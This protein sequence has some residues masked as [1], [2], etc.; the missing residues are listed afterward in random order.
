MILQ[1]K[2]CPARKLSTLLTA[3]VL[4]HFV[5]LLTRAQTLI[6]E[7]STPCKTVVIGFVGGMR[8]P[9]D[10]S[11]GVV[12]I[13]NRLKNLNQANLQVRTYSHWH[14]KQA[15]REI[16]QNIDQNQ[17]GALSKEEIR[18]A[19]K[20]VIYGHSLGGW[21]VLK[22]SRKLEKKGIP[23]EL[24]VQID[25]VGIGDEMVPGN[26]RSA[27]NYYQRTLP[28]LRGEKR[29]RAEDK[30]KTDV[31]GNF[32]IRDVGHE[33]LARRTEI[34]DFIIAN[35]RRL[36]IGSALAPDTRGSRVRT[37]NATFLID[38]RQKSADSITLTTDH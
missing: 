25:S 37:M 26:V 28:I 38:D 1:T 31:E 9:D 36:C 2:P 32:L 14:W 3:V 22:L 30:K 13:G 12:Q 35:V 29:I 21:A 19:P 8:S 10:L 24:T 17:D 4:I 11:Q 5:S 34:S 16:C 23:V 33:G 6:V 7:N 27:V 20:I 15:Y 18:R